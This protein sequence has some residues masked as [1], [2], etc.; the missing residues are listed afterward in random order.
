MDAR[1]R[2]AMNDLSWSVRVSRAEGP[3]KE[4]LADAPGVEAWAVLRYATIAIGKVTLRANAEIEADVATE[5]R[6]LSERSLKADAS[7]AMR[8]ATRRLTV[9]SATT[10]V[11]L[12]EAVTGLVVVTSMTGAAQDLPS[13]AVHP[14][15]EEAASVADD[16]V[17]AQLAELAAL[18]PAVL[19]LNGKFFSSFLF[20]DQKMTLFF[21]IQR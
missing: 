13:A 20:N 17:Q 12:E 16:H 1:C 5:T 7:S 11:A 9:Q 8:K 19:A 2:I 21:L 4:K 14:R 10:V 6:A 18:D 3:E 15:N